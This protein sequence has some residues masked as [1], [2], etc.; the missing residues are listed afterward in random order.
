MRGTGKGRRASN[1]YVLI[2]VLAALVLISLVVSRFAQRVDAL[3][4]QAVSLNAYATAHLEAV[5]AR[6]AAMYWVATRPMGRSGFGEFPGPDLRADGTPYA[7][8]SGAEVRV[9][10]LRGLFALNAVNRP[11]LI[12]MLS[13]MGVSASRAEAMVDVLLD[14]QD[15]DNLRRLQG[16]E[17]SDY[18]A[19]GLPPPRNDF[20]LVP[21]EL[22]RM[23]L[24]R[25]EP[26]LVAAIAN[27]SSVN[28][29]GMLNPNTMPSAL[30]RAAQPGAKP[31][32]IELFLTLRRA[33]GFDDGASV[34]A[35]TGLNLQGDEV[36]YHV[37]DRLRISVWA[38]GLPHALQY[39]LQ[40]VPGGASAPWQ[41]M[42]AQP[43]TR[44]R[45]TDV[46]ID[47]AIPFPLAVENLRP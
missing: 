35:A 9:Q 27:I 19:L 18:A 29:E 2:M 13:G 31:E 11:V 6:Q 26:A 5:S 32:Q 36:L 25:D 42:D 14:Y 8:P 16:A 45:S 15:T 37:S 17:A 46:N 7:L 39:N 4:A 44:A 43:E 34:Q 22:L 47:R 23:P 12:Q 24:W 21:N 20:L 3:R 28:R 10:D 1:G 41:I 38:P 33:R 30:L 40:L